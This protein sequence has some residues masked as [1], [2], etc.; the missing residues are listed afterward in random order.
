MVFTDKNLHVMTTNKKGEQQEQLC[1]QWLQRLAC[2]L[3]AATARHMLHTASCCVL[4]ALVAV[5][6]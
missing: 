2:L 3:N 6:Q 4:A 5:Q 1:V